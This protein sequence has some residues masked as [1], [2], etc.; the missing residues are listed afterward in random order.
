MLRCLRY[1]VSSRRRVLGA[2]GAILAIAFALRVAL[3]I[4]MPNQI[5]PDEHFQSIEQAHRMVFGYGVVPWEFRLGTRSWMLPG[6]LTVVIGATSWLTSSVMAYL[7]ACWTVLSAISL[8]PV[9]ATFRDT[10][11]AVRSLRA[12]VVASLM[13]ATWFELVYFAPKALGEVV[14]GNLLCVGVVLAD[15]VVRARKQDMPIARWMVP[16]AVALLT[17]A[18][19]FRI[20]LAIASFVAFVVMMRALPRR[21]QVIAL[22]TGASVIVFAGL[23]DWMTWS[24]PFQSFVENIR[25]N[26]LVGRSAHYGTAP[27]YAY[28]HIYAQLWGW[29]LI[30]ILGLAAIGARLRPLLAVCAVA[31]LVAHVPIA[32]KEYRFAYPAMVLVIMLAS[33]GAAWVITRIETRVRPRLANLVAAAFVSLWVVASLVSADGFHES[34][35][36][37]ANSFYNPQWHWTLNRGGLLALRDLGERPD[38][39]GVGLLGINMFSTGGYAYLHRDVPMFEVINNGDIAGLVPYVNYY[40]VVKSLATADHFYGFT[41]DKC[42]AQVCIFKRPGA[43]RIMPG[44]SFNDVLE[45]RGD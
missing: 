32:H 17:F 5:W 19:M 23:V 24:Y 44:Y 25:V 4:L 36:R 9:W 31:V 12:A 37:L 8:A 29:W 7:I 15:I 21:S 26:I 20:Q 11:G 42:I 13:C 45:A 43:C 22:A 30:P 34:K 41:L 18:S 14:G 28:F 35:T 33:Y 1:A 27:W 38:L 3:A 10:L 39:C 16:T 40:L 6:L 2:L